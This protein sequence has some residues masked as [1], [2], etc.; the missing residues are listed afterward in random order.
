MGKPL[1]EV[2]KEGGEYEPVGFLSG[3][4]RN[5]WVVR[6][7]SPEG[8]VYY[9]CV[10]V[11]KDGGEKEEEYFVEV[12]DKTKKRKGVYPTPFRME[13]VI[14]GTIA[15]GFLFYLSL[16]ERYRLGEKVGGKTLK[17]WYEDFI[18]F[19]EALQGRAIA[20]HTHD[21][22]YQTL[23]SIEIPKGEWP[24]YWALTIWEREELMRRF[25]RLASS[26]WNLIWILIEKV[27]LKLEKQQ[28]KTTF[29]LQDIVAF[30]E[31]GGKP[32]KTI[33]NMLGSVLFSLDKE[34]KEWV[35]SIVW[36]KLL[37]AAK[38]NHSLTLNEIRNRDFSSV[39]KL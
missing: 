25:E 11:E 5:A 4:Y 31:E 17:N 30:L 39:R 19:F 13:K 32:V 6:V 14:L 20:W 28:G 7:I 38:E 21:E 8:K 16:A 26:I 37:E 33:Q 3:R 23:Y 9:Y 29:I 27:A 10:L 34:Q 1:E 15:D 22:F 24:D 36:Q 12:L 2:L 35:S 18:R